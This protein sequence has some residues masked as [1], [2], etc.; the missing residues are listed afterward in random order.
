MLTARESLEVRAAAGLELGRRKRERLNS[1]KTVYGLFEPTGE[2]GG[3]LV[4]CLQEQGGQYVEVDT[5]PVVCLP[6]KLEPFLT[7]TQRFKVAYG[8][9]G[10]GKSQG[11]G[12]IFLGFA[13]DYGDKTLCLRELQNSIDDSVYA[14]L[15][16]Q[17]ELLEFENFS[18]V[19]QTIRFRD[20]DVFRFRG[21]RNNT[22][23]IKSAYGFRR[24]W[25]EE[26]QSLSQASIKALTPSIREAGS[27]IWL[28]MNPR[29]S[30]DPVAQ[31][32][33][34]PFQKDLDRD[35]YYEDELHLIVKINYTDNPW[36]RELEPERAFDEK[37][38]STANYRHVWLGDYNDEVEDAIIPADWFDAAIDAHVKLGFKP[39]GAKIAAF[40]PSD[41]G[42]DDKGYCLRHGSVVLDV[43][44]RAIG[45]INEGCDWALDLAINAGADHF[46]WDCDGMG[47]GLKRQVSSALKGKHLDW[48]MFQGS[49]GVESPDAEFIKT[50]E[51]DSTKRRTNKDSLYNR[52][53][54]Y[55]WRLRERFYATYRAV[56]GQYVDP[57]EILSLS[58]EIEDIEGLRAEV[59]RVPSKPNRNGKFQVMTKVEMK[60]RGIDSPNR[61]DA[62]AMDMFIPPVVRGDRAPIQFARA[63]Y[64]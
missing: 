19:N 2:Y 16:A 47:V 58:S 14:L 21:L 5:S 22:D 24:A 59:C 26:A 27:E 45:D 44:E 4:K 17:A 23:S 6:I 55:Y 36:H 38:T 34:K 20:E 39:T 1:D 51:S 33:L 48:H 11:F 40:D 28:S 12:G 43:R 41:E 62:L 9:R 7:K 42:P 15:L 32:F 8:G 60:A 37:N 10:A 3:R 35:G 52:R 18:G 63:V 50:D 53:A 29:S 61:A 64:V 49:K 54:Q 25:P 13:K 46:I 31:R 30:A 57:D 56:Q